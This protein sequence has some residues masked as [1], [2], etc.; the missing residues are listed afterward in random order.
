MGAPRMIP[1]QVA[2]RAPLPGPSATD[3]VVLAA[4]ALLVQMKARLAHEQHRA[5]TPEVWALNSALQR[6]DAEPVHMTRED[7]AAFG[8]WCT[9]WAA[10]AK[11]CLP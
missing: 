11:A 2:P 10:F 7:G 8:H 6:A 1:I 3:P 4:R 9:S 5:L